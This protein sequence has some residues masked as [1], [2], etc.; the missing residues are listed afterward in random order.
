MVSICGSR[1]AAAVLNKSL[2]MKGI[3]INSAGRQQL[4]SH[5]A[6]RDN[7]LI[8]IFYDLYVIQEIT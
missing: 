8:W 4:L 2:Y 5:L 7:R 3:Q 6:M 1:P